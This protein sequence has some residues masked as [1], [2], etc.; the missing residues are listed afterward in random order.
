MTVGIGAISRNNDG[1]SIVMAADRMVTYR[2]SIEYEDTDSKLEVITDTDAL[3]AVA[4][5]SG[6]L[7]LIDEIL[8]R[9]E[10]KMIDET[11]TDMRHLVELARESFQEMERETINNNVLSTFDLDV[12]DLSNS[13]VELPPQFE[14]RVMNDIGA[15]REEIR[16]KVNILFGGI[17]NDKPEIYTLDRADFHD[18]TSTGYAIVGSGQESAQSLFIRNRYDADEAD[19]TQAIFAVG[20][21]K[22]Q[23]EERQGVGQK[24]DMIV[25]EPGNTEQLEEIDSLR[26]SIKDI[27]EE[28]SEVRQSIMDQWSE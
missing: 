14:E 19:L 8:R 6:S 28:Q 24:M 17:S 16:K 26:R 12:S 11:P 1:P 25:V 9:L 5:G 3:T 10:N 4:V 13:D 21:A 22:V 15:V 20:E 2:S 27:S 18:H 23:A 7:S